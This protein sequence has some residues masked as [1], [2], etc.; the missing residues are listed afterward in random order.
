MP[1][2]KVVEEVEVAVEVEGVASLGCRWASRGWWTRGVWL[3][4]GGG[5]LQT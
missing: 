3:L 2:R 5:A 1:P 4:G